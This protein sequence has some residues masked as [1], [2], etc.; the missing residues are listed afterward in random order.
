M[1]MSIPSIDICDRHRSGSDRYMAQ[2]VEFA[3]IGF[4]K[5]A[6]LAVSDLLE[7]FAAV[8]SE[9]VCCPNSK[10]A[11]DALSLKLRMLA[12]ITSTPRGPQ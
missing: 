8:W 4:G 11:P 12:T 9:L 2:M 10:L 1:R 5:T 6:A 3:L 7:T